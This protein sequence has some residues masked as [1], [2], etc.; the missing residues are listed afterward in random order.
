MIYDSPILPI[1]EFSH[2]LSLDRSGGA[3]GQSLDGSQISRLLHRRDRAKAKVAVARHLL[4]RTYIMLRDEI[5]Y[6]EFLRRGVA[7]PS[8]RVSYRP[9]VPDKL[10]ERRAS[11]QQPG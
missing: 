5:D 1:I 2:S 8:A 9:Q 11:E 4:V 3:P 7:V 6:A 10:I